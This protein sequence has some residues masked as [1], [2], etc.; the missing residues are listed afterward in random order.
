MEAAHSYEGLMTS[1]QTAWYHPRSNFLV[2]KG[3]IFSAIFLIK[4]I[5]SQS[6]DTKVQ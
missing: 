3:L 2:A 1:Y 4:F 5:P 6:S